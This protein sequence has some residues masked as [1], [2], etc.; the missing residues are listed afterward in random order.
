M[1]SKSDR[2]RVYLGL[3]VVT[4]AEKPMVR[5]PEPCSDRT[6]IRPSAVYTKR[7]R[8]SQ[9]TRNGKVSWSSTRG[10][11]PVIRRQRPSWVR[12]WTRPVPS[13]V[14]SGWWITWP[15]GTVTC[16]V[17]RPVVR[18]TTSIRVLST[19]KATRSPSGDQ[20]G[21][22]SSPGPSTSTSMRPLPT[23]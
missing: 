12:W 7:S 20:D 19:T 6:W 16:V 4:A 23:S 8:S 1:L 13:G 14:H 9:D 5:V 18:S 15:A 21:S 10:V 2:R 22:Y 3:R 17:R 11:S